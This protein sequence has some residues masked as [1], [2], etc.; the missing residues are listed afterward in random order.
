M[1]TAMKNESQKLLWLGATIAAPYS[2]MCS[3]PDTCMRNQ[4]RRKGA[5]SARTNA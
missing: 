4:I 2:G 3:A 1:Q 5:T